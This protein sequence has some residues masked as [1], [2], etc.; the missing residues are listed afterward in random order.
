[1]SCLKNLIK[2][3]RILYPCTKFA[4]FVLNK[5]INRPPKPLNKER[6]DRKIQDFEEPG[7]EIHSGS[8]QV[9]ISLTSFPARIKEVK[10]AIY[11][12]LRQTYK[13]DQLVLWLGKEQFPHREA[14]LPPD[15]LK[16]RE[17]GLTI[18][19]VK[20][21]KSFKKLIPAL[22]NYSNYLIVTVDD[23]IFY[24]RYMLKKLMIEHRKYPDCIIAY[25][26]HRIQFN[27]NRLA[28]YSTWEF[29]TKKQN[30]IPS[31]LNFF[32][33]GGGVLYRSNL[34]YKDI[35]RDDIFMKYCPRANDVWFNAMAVLQGI[36][37]KII[38]GGAFPLR[39]VNPENEMNGINT[40]SSYNNGQGGNDLQIQAVLKLYPGILSK[41]L[42]D[43]LSENGGG[44]STCNRVLTYPH[45]YGWTA[46]GQAA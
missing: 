17:N 42:N 23:D 18:R 33:S 25:R 32:T 8:E 28:S 10:Y 19:F 27:D 30:K 45:P 15:L 46:F 20:D 6:L 43:E 5:I 1:M 7:I 29:E 40:L 36:K 12:L 34:L 37:T 3:N 22:Q 35:I 39:Y 44:K 16:L 13:P 24:P 11:S 14:D 2:R 9:V 41:L 4:K 26:A 31:Y 21:L 38:N